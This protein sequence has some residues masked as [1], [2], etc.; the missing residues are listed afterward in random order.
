[1][2]IADTRPTYQLVFCLVKWSPTA[3]SGAP[4]NA[5][6]ILELVSQQANRSLLAAPK[7]Q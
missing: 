2:G 5:R 3:A 7:F 6:S 1:M 4:T